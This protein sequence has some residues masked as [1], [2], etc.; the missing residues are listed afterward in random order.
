[1]KFLFS[2]KLVSWNMLRGKVEKSDEIFVI[3]REFPTVA[4]TLH[5]DIFSLAKI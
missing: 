1:M 2:L 5:A 3:S 4:L